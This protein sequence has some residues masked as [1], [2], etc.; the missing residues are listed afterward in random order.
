MAWTQADIDALKSLMASGASSIS[1]G[2]PPQRTLIARPLA[3]MQ[4]LLAQMQ[5][6]VDGANAVT[7]RL[8]ATNKGF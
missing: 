5:R 7:Y 3:E 1:Y 4:A 2:G 8:A 6:E